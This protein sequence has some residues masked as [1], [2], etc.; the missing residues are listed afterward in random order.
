MAFFN[1]SAD[2]WQRLD[3]Q[4][5][6]DGGIA[7]YWRNEYLVE[8][9]RWLNEHDYELYELDCAKWFSREDMFADFDQSF[10]FPDSWGRNFDAL[11][12]CMTDLPLDAERGAALILRRFDFYASRSGATTLPSGEV[13]AVIVLDILA[14]AS[15]FYLLNGR[16]LV[17]LV[18]SDDANLRIERLGGMAPQWNRREWLNANREPGS[19]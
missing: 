15:R 14:G 3:W 10:H 19:R 12:D 8:D 1:N 2:D 7:L 18:Q 11:N 16:R 6:R 5:L 9:A 17:V 4:V 13:E